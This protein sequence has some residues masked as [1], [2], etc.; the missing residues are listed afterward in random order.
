MGNRFECSK[1]YIKADGS[2]ELLLDTRDQKI[3]T[4]NI[5]YNPQTKMLYVPAFWKK[6]VMAFQLK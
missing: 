5:D 1:W 4:A 6:S 2:K 3:N